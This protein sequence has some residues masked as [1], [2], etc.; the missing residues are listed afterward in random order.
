MARGRRLTP[1]FEHDLARDPALG[2]EAP[3]S[4][5]FVR[6]IEHGS[7]TPLERWHCHDEYELQLIVGTRGRAFIGD[8]EGHFEPGHLVLT[9]PRLPH[10]WISTDLPPDGLAVRSL[11]LQFR[12]EPLREGMRAIRELEELRPLLERA[13]RGVEFFGIGEQVRERFQRIRA[14]HGLARFVEFAGLLCLLQRCEETRLLSSD[15]AVGLGDA[16]GASLASA[17][18]AFIDAH[19]TEALSVADVARRFHMSE[20]RFSRF[21]RQATDGTFTEFVNRA[22]VHRACE[23]LMH[24]ERQVA[25][26]C[27]AAGFN[28]IANFNRRFREIKGTTPTEFRAQHRA[29][30]GPPIPARRD[31]PQRRREP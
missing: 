12:E 22:R 24:S 25:A 15:P 28:N 11:V 26:V 10:N 1:E 8:Y 30:L 16:P 5:D 9:G 23:M 18:I 2:Y 31:A 17:A 13:R 7:P 27:F 29:R 19:C 3:G 20:S 6:C 21:L 4:D 14:S